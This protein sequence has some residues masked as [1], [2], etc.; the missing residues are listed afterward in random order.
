MNQ[1]KTFLEFFKRYC[2]DDAK[3]ALLA[4]G[5]NF[6]VRATKEPPIRVEVELSFDA[7]E[8]NALLCQIENEC[9]ELYGAA[10]FLI[11]P[12][13]PCHLFGIDCMPEIA[14][15]AVRVGAATPGFFAGARYEDDGQT[16]TVSI[17]YTESG[18]EV[19]KCTRT[20]QLLSG[21]LQS[22][23]GVSRTVRVCSSEDA[24]DR[25][26]ER[27]RQLE[28]ML[29]GFD[30]EA[31]TSFEKREQAAPEA[32]PAGGEGAPL[33]RV[34][35]LSEERTHLLVKNQTTFEVGHD[36]F[37][38]AGAKLLFGEPFPIESPT[39]LG[40]LQKPQSAAVV[41]G[42]V[43]AVTTKETKSG[44]RLQVL[45][46]LSDG[47]SAM[48]M[49]T[50]V[51]PE[52]ADCFTALKVGQS[53]ALSCRVRKERTEDE[54]YLSPN[55]AYE[56]RRVHRT[57]LSPEKRVELH[58]HT[59]MSAMDALIRPDV[60]LETVERWGH[61]AVAVT[62]HGNV[63]AFPEL[64]RVQRAMKSPVK[65]LYGMEA[66]FV[67]DT[68]RAIYGEDRPNFRDEM[69][70]F[71]IET[72][73]LSNTADRITEI[74][75]VKIRAGEITG[76]F[77]SL[78]NPGIPIPESVSR[79]T[80][81][82]DE[83]VADAPGIEE[84]LP[85]F[86]A[87]AGTCV[88]VAHNA[89][90][91]A[92]F[93]RTAAARCGLPF[94]NTYLD[95]LALS[96]YVNAELNRHGLDA[97][98]R[99]YGLEA[100]NHHRA[101]EDAAMLAQIF[102]RMQQQLAEEGVEDFA[103]MAVAMSEHTDPLRLRPHHMILFA[104]NQA[105]L[106]NLY[107]LISKSYLDYF[108]RYPRIPKSVLEQYREGLLIGSACESGELYEALLDNLSETAIEE[109]AAFYDYFEIQPLCNNRFLVDAGR[110]AD[111]AALQEI[112][113]KI[114]ALGEKLGKPVVATCDA[115][116][117]A[118][119]EEIYR[120]I[121]LKG[122]KMADGDRTAGLYLRTTEEMLGEFAYL[123]AE[124]AYEVVVTNTNRIADLIEDILPI[125]DG[126]YSPAMPGAD[127]EL[128][129]LCLQRAHALYGD[130]LPEVVANRLERELSSLTRHGFSVLYMIAQKLVAY[131]ESQGYLVG[132]RGSVG[133]SFAA[134]MA[135]ISE[136]NPLPP[137]YRCPECRYSEFITDG[138]VGA[139]FDLPDK[140]CPRCHREMTADGHDIPFETFLGFKGDKTPDIDLNFSGDVQGM[141]HKYTEELF[142]EGNVYRAG[143]IGT[144]AS[145]T[146]YG[147]LVKYL[148][149]KGLSLPRAQLDYMIEQLVGVKRTTGQHPGGII[150]IPK[151]YD[152]HDF[153]P[154]QHPADD[155]FSHIVTTHFQFSYLHDTI[156][157][158]DELGHD[159]P[160]KY[161]VLEKYTGTSVLDVKMNDPAVYA[162]FSSTKPLGITP[163]DIGGCP[164]GTWG[165]PELGTRFI[166]GVLQEARPKNFSDLVQIS[167]LTHGTN[168]WLGNAQTLIQQGHDISEV[169]G[170]RDSIML[171]LIRYGLDSALA[172]AI[173]EDVRKG[174]GVRTEYEEAMQACGV[175]DWYIAS[176][177][178]IKYMFPKAHAAAYIMS[179]IRLGWYKIHYPMAF[180]AAYL[181]VAPGG[182]DGEIVMQGRARVREVMS[183]IEK[184]G[185]DATQKEADQLVTMQLVLECMARGVRFL[186]V[187]LYLSDAS[188]FLPEDGKIR[189]PLNSLS[190]LGDTAAQ[191][192][193]Q[194]R[195]SGEI[196][197]V[198]ELRERAGLSRT[199]IDVLRKNGVLRNLSETN[200]I[201]FF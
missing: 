63:Q 115:H 62:D 129:R 13:Y 76:S 197:S 2:P 104:K 48:Y 96:R 107:R 9:R 164:L 193:V 36:T 165:L 103:G 55:A 144:L 125:P 91:D 43:F 7:P 64:L 66:Y 16:V 154:V 131:S 106:K 86:L 49:R 190:G 33:T 169:V 155:P 179:A 121:L 160:T 32:A 161:K 152:V 71:D 59:T 50:F 35:G 30:R 27:G 192:I 112:N 88:L 123:G 70:V 69:V 182:F 153:T 58:L 194:A 177:K 10:S 191:K 5:Y 142:G 158:L 40:A 110:V 56:I 77:E 87:F 6:A 168:V 14:E 170:T 24:A 151:E 120:K 126:T 180:Y 138:S 41:L 1:E 183:E 85:R 98:V 54:L 20:E 67:N 185:N 4:R 65:I 201:S 94:T 145:K 25:A 175:P 31:R 100:F 22:R 143:T 101:S 128:T 176:C 200:Q 95:T 157:K 124:K 108:R 188:A 133:S 34:S 117:L 68:A 195:E 46:G 119:E 150:V 118:P 8:S 18:V 130:P 113:R 92:G 167:G 159:I 38:T 52:E 82:T 137:H 149:E 187:D 53:I 114:V 148:E 172:Y 42:E 23:F 44:D 146:A 45:V 51:P 73:G 136:V 189:M 162:L 166:I 116:F 134:A 93:I 181:T 147:F 90:F 178:K 99:H 26:E 72:T 21:I 29:E 171:T 139:G 12:H 111:D 174:R 198:E 89:N 122:M 156:L 97:L 39:P 84:A 75:A 186:P 17:P 60:L 78:V 47:A 184:K 196:F 37:S 79:L 141:V 74:G 19:V 81:I 15:E 57:D 3:R 163:Q 173:T 109:I 132:S 83:M 135:G 102:F 199:V 28:A 140:H 127:E 105:G 61:R 11:F 80:G